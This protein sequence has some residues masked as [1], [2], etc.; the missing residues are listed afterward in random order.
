MEQTYTSIILKKRDV[1]EMD[2]LYWLYTKERGKMQVL[3][4]SV[5]KHGAKLAG[6]LENFTLA[7][8]TIVRSRGTGKI[9]GSI[10]EN[11]FTHIKH[12]L[13]ALENVFAGINIIN[14]FTDIEH[15]DSKLFSLVRE[16]LE[17][18]EN[19]VILFGKKDEREKKHRINLVTAA[20]LAKAAM[21]LGYAIEVGCCAHCGDKLGAGDTNF[22][23]R[24]GGVVCFSCA[25]KAQGL[26]HITNNGIKGLRIFM[27][28]SLSSLVK[29]RI[30]N[31]DVRSIN[32]ALSEF[33][34][35]IG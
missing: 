30:D 17:A 25:K 11:N 32:G 31:R 22:D 20:F 16:Y 9:T 15:E 12:D 28:S 21:A 18:V 27:K 7:D 4:K 23:A 2:R 8:V 1:G 24:S 13:D 34:R 19:I 14:R 5:R 3:A 29:L 6:L 33:F 26:V 35:W 10:V